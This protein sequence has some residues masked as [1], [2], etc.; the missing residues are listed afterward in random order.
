MRSDGRWR[1]PRCSAGLAGS[2]GAALFRLTSA[3][4]SEIGAGA[5]VQAAVE[6]RR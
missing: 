5:Q 6:H 4:T 2:D 3:W 1:T